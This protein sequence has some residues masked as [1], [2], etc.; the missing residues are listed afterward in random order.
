MNAR[1]R[2]LII[3]VI[4][5]LASIAY[6]L[7]SHFVEN[8]DATHLTLY[9]N[10][11]IREVELAFRV[12]GRLESMRYDEGDAVEAGELLAVL[13]SEPYEETLGVAR[14]RVAQAGA[15][16]SKLRAG[17]RPQEIARARAG[18]TEAQV[19][20]T[21]AE[22]EFQRVSGLLESGASSEKARDAAQA[23]RAVRRFR[24]KVR[25]SLDRSNR[26]SP[27]RRAHLLLPQVLS[28]SIR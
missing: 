26:P 23:R 25:R 19:A 17:S 18:V 4:V 14:A 15:Q 9:G 5:A 28:R 2:I 8:D 6:A 1:K 7:W 21:N 20:Y 11:D 16:L 12:A 22:R 24:R 10:V 3:V 27:S 13:D